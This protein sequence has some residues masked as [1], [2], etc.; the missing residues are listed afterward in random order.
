[1]SIG[2]RQDERATA[3]GSDHNLS[4]VAGSRMAHTTLDPG[5]LSKRKRPLIRGCVRIRFARSQ[6]RQR[7][8]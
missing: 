7:R 4:A 5:A 3:A 8:H 2:I 6:K 1:M